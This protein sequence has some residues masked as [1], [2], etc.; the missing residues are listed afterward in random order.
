VLDAARENH[1]Q[2]A[3]ALASTPAPK[4]L[5]VRVPGAS[6]GPASLFDATVSAHYGSGLEPAAPVAEPEPDSTWLLDFLGDL[7]DD[8][9][10]GAGRRLTTACPTCAKLPGWCEECQVALAKAATYSRI[11]ELIEAAPGDRGAVLVLMAGVWRQT[12]PETTPIPAQC[13]TQDES[14]TAEGVTAW[15]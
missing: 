2:Y 9:A 7:L 13:G 15:H 10:E 3:A 1:Q 11:A 4:P 6:L 12:A 14:K 5:P 8:A